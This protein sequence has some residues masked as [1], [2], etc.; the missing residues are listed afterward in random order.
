MPE[1]L[2]EKWRLAQDL[3]DEKAKAEL[4]KD[5]TKFYE[6]MSS[7][8]N[9]KFQLISWKLK[10]AALNVKRRSLHAGMKSASKYMDDFARVLP[11]I[12]ELS[13][14]NLELDEKEDEDIKLKVPEIVLDQSI[15]TPTEDSAQ[16]EENPDA[17]AQDIPV[18][19]D[20]EITFKDTAIEHPEK[21]QEPEVSSVDQ[22]EVA[23]PQPV[24]HQLK[25][26]EAESG[27]SSLE[28]KPT[29]VEQQNDSITSDSDKHGTN[30]TENS[31]DLRAMIAPFVE[32]VGVLSKSVMVHFFQ[33]LRFMD[34]LN[35]IKRLAFLEDRQ[36]VETLCAMMSPDNRSLWNLDKIQNLTNETHQ[37]MGACLKLNS[38]NQIVVSYNV[39]PPIDQV[40]TSEA[41]QG[42]EKIS[43]FLIM[44][45]AA[46]AHM[47]AYYLDCIKNKG[48]QYIRYNLNIFICISFSQNLIRTRGRGLLLSTTS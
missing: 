28:I 15:L 13:A 32:R 8:Q 46:K 30:F 20:S 36:I 7:M 17:S 27:A 1:K 29:I 16:T 37:P 39:S 35:A 18:S 6:T 11:D 22:L 47:T 10:R 5:L 33:E 31:S 25:D 9:V 21:K 38:T 14:E 40:I 41:V 42:M 2:D 12:L 34:H 43:G 4:Q 48:K 44:L 3:E 45:E 24:K 26:K 23:L 19:D